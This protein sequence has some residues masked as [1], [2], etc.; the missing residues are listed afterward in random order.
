MVKA[1]LK[2]VW[3][4]Q[5]TE[6]LKDIFDYHK[7]KSTQKAKSLRSDILNAPKKIVFAQQYQV[8]DINPKYRRIVIRDYKLIY[9]EKDNTILVIDIVSTKQS[10]DI[11]KGK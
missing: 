9:R 1:R 7:K 2:I 8:D 6:S 11:L 5:A 3:S 10:P 4:V